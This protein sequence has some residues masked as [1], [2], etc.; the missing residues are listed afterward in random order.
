[1]AAA[2]GSSASSA[3]SGLASSVRASGSVPCSAGSRR[4]GVKRRRAVL[5]RQTRGLWLLPQLGVEGA[6]HH[7]EWLLNTSHDNLS[8]WLG[9]VGDRYRARMG[10]RFTDAGKADWASFSASRAML[11]EAEIE[12]EVEAKAA[13]VAEQQAALKAKYQKQ[14]QARR[15][16]P[17]KR[18]A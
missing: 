13:E 16:R 6:S 4:I 18:R 11:T 7:L 10:M 15:S 1:M 12:A 14:R 2:R 5:G 3:A 17:I 9:P 8:D